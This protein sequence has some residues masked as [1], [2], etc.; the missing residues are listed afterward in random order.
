MKILTYNTTRNQYW[1]QTAPQTFQVGQIMSSYVLD[2]LIEIAQSD[3]ATIFDITNI[4]EDVY[5]RLVRKYFNRMGV[6][7]DTEEYAEALR[8]NGAEE[9]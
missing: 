1:Y 7:E 9:L 2:A 3:G 6:V 8:L 4:P 5:N